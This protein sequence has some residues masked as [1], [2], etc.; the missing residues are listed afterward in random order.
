MSNVQQ[1]DLTFTDLFGAAYDK[2]PA[3]EAVDEIQNTM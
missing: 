1:F 2:R 3:F